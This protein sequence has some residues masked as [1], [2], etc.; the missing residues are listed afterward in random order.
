[1]NLPVSPQAGLTAQAPDI[2]RTSPPHREFR[3]GAK[4]IVVR[5]QQ[6]L[7][8]KER[9]TNGTTFW[10]LP[11]GGVRPDESIL[12]GLKR[13]FR[14]ELSV[15]IATQSLLG[16][17]TYDHASRPTTTSVYFVFDC[18]LTGQPHPNGRDDIID[19]QWKDIGDLPRTLIDS[20]DRFLTNIDGLWLS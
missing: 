3:L 6:V 11:G 15:T 1:M 20:F 2:L 8:T 9:R 10:T 4:G 13:E 7:L 12:T 14:E 18:S 5:H 17:C 19:A 16:T